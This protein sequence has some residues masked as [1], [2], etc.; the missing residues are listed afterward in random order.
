MDGMILMVGDVGLNRWWVVWR[1]DLKGGNTK[2]ATYKYVLH[3]SGMITWAGGPSTTPGD[4]IFEYRNLGKLQ[5]SKLPFQS[6]IPTNAFFPFDFPFRRL[7]GIAILEYD[8]SLSAR[9]KIKNLT[10]AKASRFEF[11]NSKFTTS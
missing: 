2:E 11:Q 9:W 8:W 1:D 7:A 5:Q 3:D 6:A 10:H 4:E